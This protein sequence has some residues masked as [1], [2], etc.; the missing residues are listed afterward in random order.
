MSAAFVEGVRAALILILVLAAASKFH[1]YKA[2]QQAL[3]AS[4]LTRDSARVWLWLVPASEVG[5]AGLL[6]TARSPG[7]LSTG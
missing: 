2:F 3:S 6:A 4:P 7:V 1:D 5:L